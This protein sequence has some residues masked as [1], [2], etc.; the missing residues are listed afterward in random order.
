MCE[1]PEPLNTACLK[2]L[3]KLEKQT[4]FQSGKA[5]AGVT[6]QCKN[7]AGNTGQKKGGNELVTICPICYKI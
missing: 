6:A 3:G 2:D 4:V 1:R 7:A 5:M